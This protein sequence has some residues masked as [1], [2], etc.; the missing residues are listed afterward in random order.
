[1]FQSSTAS[2]AVMRH[3]RC[4]SRSHP[5][6]IT[7]CFSGLQEVVFQPAKHGILEAERWS[8]AIRKGTFLKTG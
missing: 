5:P 2:A 8:F 7:L 4:D 3:N 1:M 6:H